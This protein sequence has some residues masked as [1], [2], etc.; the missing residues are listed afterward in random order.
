MSN[1]LLVF[2]N[3]LEKIGEFNDI[4]DKFAENGYA[5]YLWNNI[6][7]DENFSID[8]L[9]VIVG[10][11][12]NEQ[13]DINKIVVLS[14]ARDLIFSWYRCYNSVVDDFIYFIDKDDKNYFNVSDRHYDFYYNLAEFNGI[15][16]ETVEGQI[17]L[18]IN[19][20]NYEKVINLL[21]QNNNFKYFD[22]IVNFDYKEKGT[23]K[24]GKSKTYVFKGYEYNF[25]MKT[26]EKVVITDKPKEAAIDEQFINHLLNNRYLIPYVTVFFL[27]ANNNALTNILLTLFRKLK[28]MKKEEYKGV[29]EELFAYISR[30]TIIFKERFYIASLLVMIN[31]GDERLTELMMKSLL[32]DEEYIEYHHEILANILFYH[33]NENL[34]RYEGYYLDQRNIVGKLADWVL[35]D[36]LEIKKP[37]KLSS[38]KIALVV[39]QLISINHS[40]TKLMLDYAGNIKKYYQ[41]YEVK[42]FVEDNLYCNN[43]IMPYIYSSI[44]SSSLKEEHDRYLNDNSIVIYYANINLAKKDRTKEII[45]EIKKFN[46][47]AILTNSDIST[48]SRI[49]YNKYPIIYM[50]MG[51]DYYSN[52]ADAYLCGVKTRVIDSNKKYRLLDEEKIHEFK[53]GLEFKAPYKD[54]KRSDYSIN[55]NDFV[56]VTVGNRLDA[57]MDE[58]FLDSIAKFLVDNED[59]K[60]LIVGPRQISYIETKY[61]F[62]L[63]DKI[64][65]IPYE[66][67]LS[68]L[69]RICD[70]YINPRRKGGGIS[71]AMA[72]NEGL[73]IAVFAD[74]SDGA[75]F[76]ELNNCSG[77][78]M[79][80]YI[81]DLE[82]LKI[83]NQYRKL[84]GKLMFEN[85]NKLTIEKTVENLLSI[86]M[87]I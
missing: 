19:L 16:G 5:M 41:D 74:K 24:K 84:K 80:E 68:A 85:I 22:N 27:K 70:V 15:E 7:E 86:I 59:N 46:P 35:D 6:K 13:E 79:Q 49:F 36:D 50:S 67:D 55:E 28:V 25:A 30:P 23:A 48:V 4:I 57:E 42:I 8:M 69:Y 33:S 76:V 78:T 21:L 72:M 40:P 43:E 18:N 44:I 3:E 12:K 75:A 83:D 11:Y 64:I 61:S 29:Y 26:Q 1:V 56:M 54:I 38:K 2:I 32:E 60:W 53:Y 9:P 45:R 81:Q 47:E 17:Y 62:L 10:N 52:L 65:K 37:S 34:V 71:I 51:G 73:P 66:D 77:F 31:G 20:S 87:K 58:E 14:N 39:D 82:T 63:N